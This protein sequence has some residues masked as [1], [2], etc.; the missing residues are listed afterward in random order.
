MILK[1]Y[2]APTVEPVLGDELGSHLRV[3]DDPMLTGYLKAAR[4]YVESLCGPLITQTWLQYED[5]WPSGD[6]LKIGKPRLQS[7]TSITYLDEDAVS[8]TLSASSY[9]VQTAA[10]YAPSV[11]LKPDESWPSEVLFN[12]NPITI[13][14]VCGYGAN[15]T[16]VPEPIRLAIMILVGTWY[17]NREAVVVSPA[18]GMGA[19]TIPFSVDALLSE[20]RWWT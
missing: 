12:S 1:L 20:Y 9:T 19:A 2:T 3:G 15:A 18:A 17:E 10:E 8:S 5:E 4:Q 16:Y 14:F 6:V 7:V 13:T 11:V